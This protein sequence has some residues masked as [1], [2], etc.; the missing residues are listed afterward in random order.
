VRS[1]SSR[2][3]DPAGNVRFALSENDAGI[4]D[5]AAM[6]PVPLTV[7]PGSI[8]IGAVTLSTPLTVPPEAT[9]SS[10]ALSAPLFDNNNEP[11]T[12]SDVSQS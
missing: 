8:T 11:A 3:G 7:P 10:G 1:R 6:V 4:V 12:V 5:W 9:I 2:H